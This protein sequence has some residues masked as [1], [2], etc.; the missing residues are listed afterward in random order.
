M[1]NSSS[2]RLV[3][4][5]RRWIAGRAPG[6]RLPATRALVRE[7]GVG[8]GTVQAALRTLAAE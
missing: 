7:H 8:P 6:S 2:S 4:E 5:L 3:S 1:S